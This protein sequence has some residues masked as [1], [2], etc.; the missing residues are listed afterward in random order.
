MLLNTWA[1]LNENKLDKKP[2][3]KLRNLSG[4]DILHFSHPSKHRDCQKKTRLKTLH[5]QR[6]ETAS[7]NKK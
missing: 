1:R 2:N 6:P 3:F 4:G 5:V 7:K